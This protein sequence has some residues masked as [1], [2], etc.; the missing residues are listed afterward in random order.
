LAGHDGRQNTGP[1]PK[2]VK[3]AKKINSTARSRH[4]TRAP[5]WVTGSSA[6][7]SK[8]RPTRRKKV[9]CKQ[10]HTNFLMNHHTKIEKKNHQVD[11]PTSLVAL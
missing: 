8:S 3:K 6:D 4:E 9:L 1:H 10:I 7:G 11:S 2:K 5:D